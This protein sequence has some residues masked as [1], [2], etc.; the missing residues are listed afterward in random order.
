MKDKILN[1]NRKKGPNPDKS[2][3]A[4]L[5]DNH[6]DTEKAATSAKKKGVIS[7]MNDNPERKK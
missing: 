6:A 7:K 3:L 4:K 1:K 5:N 2:V